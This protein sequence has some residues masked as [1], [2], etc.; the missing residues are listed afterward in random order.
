MSDKAS[1]I[2][3]ESNTN[4]EEEAA[5]AKLWAVYVSEAEKYDRALVESWKSDMEGLL[6]FA[7]LF[8]SILT[9]F[10]IE[11]YQSLNPDSGDLTVHFLAQISQQ[12]AASANGSTFD[13]PRP[14]TFS[15]TTSSIVCNALWFSSLGFS[16][17]CALIATF[18]QQWARDF[19]HKT[20]MRSAPVIRARIFSY[21][22]YGLKRFQM[23]TVVEIIPLLLHGSLV[24][25]FCGLVAFLIPV[26][27]VMTV[28]ASTVLGIITAV[29]C[30]L[31]LLPLRY[32]DC[33]YRTPLSGA[34]WQ[35]FR[36]FQSFWHHR[37]A[38]P[39]VTIEAGP[40][41][42]ANSLLHDYD[43]TMVEAMSRIALE[44]RSQRD[45]KTLVWTMKSLADDAELEPFMEAIPDILWAPDYRRYNYEGH[46]RG[47]IH[48]PEIQLL[49]RL[50]D[51]LGS[52]YSGVLSSEASQRR[53][54]TCH[55]AIWAIGTLSQPNRI[56][57]VT[58]NTPLD[59]GLLAGTLFYHRCSETEPYSRPAV[60]IFVWSTFLAVGA[61]LSKLRETLTSSGSQLSNPEVDAITSQLSALTKKI[62]PRIHPPS[63]RSSVSQLRLWINTAFAEV[64][65]RIFLNF[66]LDSSLSESLPYHWA[67]TRLILRPSSPP[68][69]LLKD[70]IK[71]TMKTSI[72][73]QMDRLNAKRVAGS[74]DW[75]FESIA[76][77]LSLWTATNTDCIPSAII[78]LLNNFE[79]DHQ[80]REMLCIAHKEEDTVEI[81]LWGYF[82]ET[83]LDVSSGRIQDTFA[84]LWRLA[85]SI[86]L[87]DQYHNG[88]R[89]PLVE[90]LL[91][92]LSRAGTPFP[93][94]TQS[95]TAL[96][97]VLI[98]RDHNLP[99]KTQE[100]MQTYVYTKT[101]SPKDILGGLFVPDEN[102]MSVAE[103]SELRKIGFHR[104]SEPCLGIVAEYLEHCTSNALPYKAEETL[105]KITHAVYLT[106]A[107]PIN[108]NLQMRLANCIQSLFAAA[109]NMGLL[110]EIVT[111]PLW[112][113][114]GAGL[115]AKE[116]V[117]VRRRQFDRLPDDPRHRFWPWLDNTEA[118]RK[119]KT[120]FTDY[121]RD[122]TSTID[123]P[124]RRFLPHLQAVLQGMEC[125]HPEFLEETMGELE[126]EKPTVG[127]PIRG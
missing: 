18:V 64:P 65:Y 110:D 8:S 102:A 66:L 105:R 9:A 90:A 89:L 41:H 37:H 46:I 11:S 3:H 17:G 62:Y 123:S 73:D 40:P 114:Y 63:D 54:I 56:S 51:L 104:L 85:S 70:M 53:Q 13:V 107:E 10:I 19:L 16:L 69:V 75:V 77:I 26:N 33:P 27:L 106:P 45:Y 127:N 93:K 6:I 120:A 42:E 36:D 48:N 14:T 91:Q 5:S 57:A 68:P 81:H 124:S 121:E 113:V 116:E 101:L 34:F 84:A 67:E 88:C 118:R 28:I 74:L 115:K 61:D 59:L 29:Y 82:P 92:T 96:L 95:V 35:V 103:W 15:P 71:D 24:L 52:C 1:S 12:L 79:R 4:R 39:K 109:T 32:L 94:L 38:H 47:L 108:H 117:E 97:K 25:F 112:T 86:G 2:Y 111:C 78:S 31:T 58:E 20:D 122:L 44:T 21:L 23:H 99:F 43:E 119:I 83:I 30:T 125:W 49:N 80:L 72:S 7:A 76:D 87:Q 98:L 100:Q 60:H 126:G 22:Y 55:K 50:R